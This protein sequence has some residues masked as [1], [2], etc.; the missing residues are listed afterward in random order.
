MMTQTEQLR[1]TPMPSPKPGSPWSR[2]N[3]ERRAAKIAE[4]RR[5]YHASVPA[6]Q[7]ISRQ[8][9]LDEDRRQ[10]E[11][12]CEL[13]GR[14][15]GHARARAKLEAYLATERRWIRLTSSMFVL[16]GLDGQFGGRG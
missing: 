13:E 10:A 14:R 16:G 9:C 5:A 1:G 15:I 2:A 11:A 3:P 12:L 7:P 6:L 4:Y 8:Q